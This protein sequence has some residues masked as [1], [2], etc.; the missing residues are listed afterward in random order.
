MNDDLIKKTQIDVYREQKNRDGI[1]LIAAGIFLI[2]ISILMAFD[3]VT[4]AGIFVIVI[5][6][7]IDSLR[8][9]FTY[10]RIGYVKLPDNNK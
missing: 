2:I 8:K 4:F 10:P 1:P 7:V 6:L 3:K 5:P 9:R